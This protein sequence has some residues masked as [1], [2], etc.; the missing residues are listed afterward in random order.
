MNTRKLEHLHIFDILKGTIQNKKDS[1]YHNGDHVLFSVLEELDT[2]VLDLSDGVGSTNCHWEASRLACEKS[3]NKFEELFKQDNRNNITE[4]M[5]DSIQFANTEIMDSATGQCHGMLATLVFVVWQ[6]SSNS[7]YYYSLG[8][9]RLYWLEHTNQLHQLTKDQAKREMVY[10]N[11]KPYMQ[12][13]TVVYR[14]F[15][16]NA[17]GKQGASIKIEQND[18][19]NGDSL[20]LV[21]DG[22]Y[23][24]HDNFYERIVE[25]MN[26]LDF[27]MSFNKLLTETGAKNNDDASI[28]SIRRNDFP[29][30]DSATNKLPPHLES[31]S[32][33]K[34]LIQ[35][36]TKNEKENTLEMIKEIINKNYNLSINNY[37]DILQSFSKSKLSNDSEIWIEL[38][39]LAQL[40]SK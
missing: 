6:Y 39:K 14:N 8:D 17:L 16:T 9:S 5:M 1:Q 32:F 18:F 13:G 35:N 30:K 22:Y 25:M 10:K 28:I 31:A 3:I 29:N 24:C 27:E 26:T 21:T 36:L 34:M 12:N 23:E 2:V 40:I 11:G 33:S 38:R 37:N 7:I 19:R 20:V 15:I 4:I